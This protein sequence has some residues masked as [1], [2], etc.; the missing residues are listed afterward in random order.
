MSSAG[1]FRKRRWGL[2]GG[3]AAVVV[4][5]VWLSTDRTTASY[6]NDVHALARD[7][8]AVKLLDTPAEAIAVLVDVEQRLDALPTVDVDPRALDAANG[9]RVALV[10]ARQCVETGQRM[11]DRPLRTSLSA[12]VGV[13][14]GGGPLPELRDELVRMRAV[15]VQSYNTAVHARSALA[16]RYPL[17]QFKQPIPP[18]THQIDALIDELDRIIADR[19]DL[20]E[21]AFNLGRLLGA[22]A[23]LL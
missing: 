19:D 5:I 18:D 9:F 20:S 4:A 17:S 6:W 22:L 2:I 21:R 15:T 14:T 11:I 7:A 13:V 12:A 3:G 16:W 23:S 8:D 10:A 1:S